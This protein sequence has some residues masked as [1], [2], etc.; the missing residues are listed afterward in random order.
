MEGFPG[1]SAVWFE[2]GHPAR[3]SSREYNDEYQLMVLILENVSGESKGKKGGRP[4]G[5]IGDWG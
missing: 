5:R 2:I 1:W 4:A 3:R